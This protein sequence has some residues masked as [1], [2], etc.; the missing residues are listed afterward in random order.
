MPALRSE[1]MPVQAGS[2]RV[3]PLAVFF[4]MNAALLCGAELV[5][6]SERGYN[7]YKIHFGW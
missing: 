2:V 3:E 6:D 5:V 1:G 7:G 4:R